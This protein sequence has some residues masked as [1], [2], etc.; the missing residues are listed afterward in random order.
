MM[1]VKAGTVGETTEC[2]DSAC[3]EAGVVGETTETVDSA[4]EEAGVVGADDRNCRFS[5][6]RSGYSA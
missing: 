2:V 6:R 4:C 5:A 3:E 1:L